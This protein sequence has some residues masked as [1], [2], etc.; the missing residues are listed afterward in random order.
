ME[1][2]DENLETLEI[3]NDKFPPEW[4]HISLVAANGRPINEIVLMDCTMTEIQ[5]FPNLSYI[6]INDCPNLTRIESFPENIKSIHLRN[7]P[8]LSQIPAF[9]IYNN[10][11]DVAINNCA[12]ITSLNLPA[13]LDRLRIVSC[14]VNHIGDISVRLVLRLARVPITQLPTLSP[15]L[16]TLSLL[17]CNA[18]QNLSIPENLKNLCINNCPQIPFPVTLPACLNHFTYNDNN[19]LTIN[20]LPDNLHSLALTRVQALPSIPTV[21]A[22][23]LISSPIVDDTFMTNLPNTLRNLRLSFC[24]NL[25][26]ITSLPP[27]QVITF[28]SLSN[29][30]Q[31]DYLPD[32]IH[33]ITMKNCN[34][35]KLYLPKS[36]K[37]LHLERTPV[38]QFIGGFSVLKFLQ[39][40]Y[41]GIIDF[42]PFPD[43]LETFKINNNYPIDCPRFPAS[44][45]SLKYTNMKN[46]A[47]ASLHRATSLE[48]LQLDRCPHLKRLPTLP[49]GVKFKL[50]V[51]DCPLLPNFTLDEFL[52]LQ[53]IRYRLNKWRLR[54][55]FYAAFPRW[56]AR[57]F[58][59]VHIDITHRPGTGVE[60]QKMQEGLTK[61]EGLE[62]V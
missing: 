38:A 57:R 17:H 41:C 8:M 3:N 25:R 43:T 6:V 56:R 33:H 1:E 16:T 19:L 29:L 49:E 60:W 58:A 20:T 47:I 32:T 10:L 40:D 22:L 44:L 4:P 46:A 2:S 53:D 24:P 13:V 21:V 45:K 14:P 11:Y 59:A 50:E 37:T 48:K 9:N 61:L 39:V 55:L 62:I 30:G 27:L 23:M 5:E 28:Y 12:L 7:L 15:N 54:K 34:L 18:L 42:P 31:L 51:T 26:Q 36:L 52:Y 35:A